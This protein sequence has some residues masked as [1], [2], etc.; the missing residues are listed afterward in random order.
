[1]SEASD[2]TIDSGATAH[3]FCDKAFFVEMRSSDKK[4]KV[5]DGAMIDVDP[6]SGR[7]T[8]IERLRIDVPEARSCF[9]VGCVRCRFRAPRPSLRI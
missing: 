6:K 7:A 2:I 9:C 3:A 5:A 8:A 1:M 4:V